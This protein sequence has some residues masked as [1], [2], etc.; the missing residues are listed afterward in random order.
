[1]EPEPSGD[2]EVAVGN[3]GW[4]RI[5]GRDGESV[6][7]AGMTVFARVSLDAA[8]RLEVVEVFVANDDGSGLTASDWRKI[9]VGRIEKLANHPERAEVIRSRLDAPGPPLGHAAR[10][11][12][13]TFGPEVDHWAA[14]MLRSQ[15]G[16]GDDVWPEPRQ[17]SERG[18]PVD[19]EHCEHDLSGVVPTPP[20]VLDDDF[21]AAV[22]ET[23]RT[24]VDHDLDPAPTMQAANGLDKVSTVHYWIRTAREHGHL[25][26][27]RRGKAG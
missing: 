26:P 13:T 6:A 10:F 18:W 23:Y 8:R 11:F 3:G 14:G 19:V 17:G 9:R 15:T 27:G 4:L 21:L 24:L 7:P 5:T 1:M 12:S 20:A 2:D 22:A 16:D 25:A